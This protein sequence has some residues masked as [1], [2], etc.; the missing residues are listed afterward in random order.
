MNTKILEAL[1][2]LDP[3]DDGHWT[4]QGLPRMDVVEAIVGDKGIKRGDITNAAPGFTRETPQLPE[5]F[6]KTLKPEASL[7]EEEEEEEPLVEDGGQPPEVSE[8]PV[9][10]QGKEPSQ[11]DLFEKEIVV[12]REKK[13]VTEK[14][15]EAS[16]GE[17]VKLNIQIDSIQRKLDRLNQNSVNLHSAVQGALQQQSKVRADRAEKMRKLHEAGFDPA[18]IQSR[19][20][21]DAAMARKRG[22]GGN[23][24]KFP[25]L[26]HRGN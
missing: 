21:I 16:K 23:R 12:L 2:Q 5:E 3:T 6:L 22:R 10:E 11:A 25:T 14:N 13:A 18:K 26:V 9:T 17:L 7:E 1:Q 19:A 4:N 15:I 20:Q 24:P 8:E